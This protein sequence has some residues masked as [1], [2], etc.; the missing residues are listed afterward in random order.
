MSSLDVARR[1]DRLRLLSGGARSALSP[2]SEPDRDDRLVLP[3]ARRPEQALFMRLSVFAGGFDL[4][5]G[6]RR[7]RGGRRRPRTTPSNCSP[8]W[9][10][11]RWWCARSGPD[12]T[13]YARAGDAARLRPGASCGRTGSANRY[14]TQAF[15]RTSP[16]SPSAPPRACTARMN[17]RGSSGCCPTTTTCGRRSSARWPTA[18]STWRCGWSRRCPS[19]VH[20]RVGYEPAGW[21][22]RALDLAPTG[23]PACSP[24]R[25]GSPR[26]G[27]EP[28]RLRPRAGTGGARRRA[29]FPVAAPVASRIPADV[30]ADVAALRR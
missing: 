24:P 30:L 5:S 11:S 8:G 2:T 4:D 20:L 25:S 6:A 3:P 21:A 12:R 7:V 17:G 16:S 18:T 22:E 27:V 13:R 28:W 26:G 10:T 19:S 1:L 9:S 14:A 29:G 23:P 15:G